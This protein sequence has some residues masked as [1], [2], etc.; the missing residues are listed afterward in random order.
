[1]DVKELSKCKHIYKLYVAKDNSV[2]ME[3]YP[4]IYANKSY[5]YFKAGGE[6]LGSVAFKDVLDS[7]D[8]WLSGKAHVSPYASVLGYFWSIEDISPEY[9]VDLEK[10]RRIVEI[11]SLENRIEYLNEY[12]ETHKRL[13][14]DAI[15]NMNEHRRQIAVLKEIDKIESEESRTE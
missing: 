14:F 6:K 11:Q 1:M 3:K 15:N 12:A 4:I 7:F 9:L 5:V 8:D 13:Y 10:L 2:H